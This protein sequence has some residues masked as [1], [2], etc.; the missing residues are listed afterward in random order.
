MAKYP[1]VNYTRN[2]HFGAFWGDLGTTGIIWLIVIKTVRPSGR[3]L[4]TDWM[5]YYNRF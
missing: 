3:V 1:K 4:H 2:L 5:R